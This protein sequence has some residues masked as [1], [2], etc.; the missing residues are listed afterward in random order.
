MGGHT[1]L[2]EYLISQG[3]DKDM[4]G[5]EGKWKVTPVMAAADKGHTAVVKL[6]VRKGASLEATDKVRRSFGLNVSWHR[7][8]G[9]DAAFPLAPPSGQEDGTG[10]GPAERPRPDRGVPRGPYP[11]RGRAR[12]RH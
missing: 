6:L 4:Q 12:P 3:V 9:L 2:A 11:R 8:L 1:D 5:K 10:L 7:V